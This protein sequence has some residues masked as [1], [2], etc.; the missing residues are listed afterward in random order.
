MSEKDNCAN[1]TAEKTK[2][3][4][5]EKAEKA[6]K[7]A[8]EGKAAVNAAK[9]EKKIEDIIRPVEHVTSGA[10]KSSAELEKSIGKGASDVLKQDAKRAA[11]NVKPKA[12]E[13]RKLDGR[14]NREIP[15]NIRNNG[16]K[17]GINNN[18]I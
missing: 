7:A 13:A 10:A 5:A 16:G 14:E 17:D 11:K 2:A 3:K 4:A 9:V 1:D 15:E 18:T 12:P 6:A 8:K